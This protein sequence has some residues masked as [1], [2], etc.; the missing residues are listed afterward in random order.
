VK[1]GRA[2]HPFITGLILLYWRA[3]TNMNPSHMPNSYTYYKYY[4]LY[5]YY[6]YYNTPPRK[7]FWKSFY[8]HLLN[9]F[10]KLNETHGNTNLFLTKYF[11]GPIGFY[12]QNSIGSTLRKLCG[13]PRVRKK[14]FLSLFLFILCFWNPILQFWKKREKIIKIYALSFQLML[15]FWLHKSPGY[16]STIPAYVNIKLI[17]H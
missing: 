3:S 9:S 15:D 17:T 1:I 16:F 7:R 6:N 2:S 10:Y 8:D 14:K 13:S 11:I 5:K 12:S 4:V